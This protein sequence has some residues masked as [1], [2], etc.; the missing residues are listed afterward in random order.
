M[1]DVCESGELDEDVFDELN[2]DEVE[3]SSDSE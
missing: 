1:S 3:N 2:N